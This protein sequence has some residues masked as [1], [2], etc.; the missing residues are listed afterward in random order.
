MTKYTLLCA[1]AMFPINKIIKTQVNERMRINFIASY[2][3][4]YDEFV[5]VTEAS[6]C[7]RKTATGQDRDNTKNNIQNSQYTKKQKHNI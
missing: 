3:Y 6:Q 7:N 2:V 4:T 1:A 5:I